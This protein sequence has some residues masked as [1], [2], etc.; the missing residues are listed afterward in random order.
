MTIS[1][2]VFLDLLKL[3]EQVNE[4]NGNKID[5]TAFKIDNDVAEGEKSIVYDLK[6][7]VIDDIIDE[8]KNMKEIM[9]ELNSIDVTKSM[10]ELNYMY[11]FKLNM[12]K[13]IGIYSSLSSDFD[14]L[15]EFHSK[16][17]QSFPEGPKNDSELL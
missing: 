11:K 12:V 10:E 3:Y 5:L 9:T 14:D 1:S 17:L 2:Q 16:F 8:L 4:K 7:D 15:Y 6:E 13:L